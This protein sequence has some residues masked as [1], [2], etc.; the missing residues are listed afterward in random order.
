MRKYKTDTVELK[1]IMAEKGIGTILELSELTGINR[2]TLGKIM[3]GTAQPSSDAMNRLVF[4]L[5]IQPERA[6]KIFFMV[7]LRSA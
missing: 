3:N 5:E 1:K 6:G 7:D 2:N 4:S